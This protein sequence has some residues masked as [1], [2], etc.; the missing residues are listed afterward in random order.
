MFRRP[1][2]HRQRRLETCRGRSQAYATGV[3]V[4]ARW[5]GDGKFYESR[6]IDFDPAS[7]KYKLQ[8]IGFPEF[9]WQIADSLKPFDAPSDPP[10][11]TT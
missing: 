6:V 10:A 9:F 11:Y 2:R 7:A 3:L 4:S 1:R 5:D 8:A